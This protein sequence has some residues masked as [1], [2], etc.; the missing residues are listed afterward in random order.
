MRRNGDLLLSLL[1]SLALCACR[2]EIALG[3]GAEGDGGIESST[4]A[5]GPSSGSG[6]GSSST[7]S[8]SGGSGSSSSA[9]CT[10]APGGSSGGSG[11]TPVQLA[12]LQ[13]P[14]GIAV[15]ATYAYVASYEI[16]PVNRVA[17]DGSGVVELD[18]V[19]ATNVAVN[20][21]NV[22]TVSPSGGGA[23][24]GLVVGCAKTG[25]GGEYTTLASG[26]TE[27][28]GVAADDTNVYWTNQG[29]PEPGLFKAPIGGGAPV[30]L[31]AS[32]PANAVVA[33]GGR[34][35]YSGSTSGTGSGNRDLL[36]V[37]ANGGAPT[38]LV[39]PDPTVSVQALTVDCVNVYYTTTDGT[40]AQIPIGGGIPTTLATGPQAL[41]IA[42]DADRVYF[43]GEQGLASVPIGGGTVT[44]LVTG[45]NPGGIAVDANNVYWTNLGDGTV[46][47]LAK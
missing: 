8:G 22:Y 16:G 18:S 28:W 37:S 43:P 30:A 1:G 36:S 33:S 35:F 10:P 34:V 2:G 9:G 45:V 11:A 7:G 25:C 46:M 39:S 17:L 14:S 12:Q 38:V 47:K 23:P 32:G 21:T 5:T 40:V 15:D 13:V 42:V 24:Q 26:Q 20:T 6:G 4:P 44:T 41:Q 19:S 29:Q 27:V 31:S 3:G